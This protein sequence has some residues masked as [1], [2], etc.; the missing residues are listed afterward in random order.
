MLSDL[1]A[2]LMSSNASPMR[3]RLPTQKGPPTTRTRT[4]V[5]RKDE[6][7]RQVPQRTHVVL[8]QVLQRNPTSTVNA[9]DL[10]PGAIPVVACY[11]AAPAVPDDRQSQATKVRAVTVVASCRGIPEVVQ[12]DRQA[13]ATEVRAVTVVASCRGILEVSRGL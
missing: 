13:R 11:Q 9:Q 4:L 2:R 10:T 6:A 7:V 1:G 8:P 3:L 5:A 12:D